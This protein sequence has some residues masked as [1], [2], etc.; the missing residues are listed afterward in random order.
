MATTPCYS[1][2]FIAELRYIFLLFYCL[3][4]RHHFLLTF[5]IF[6]WE[7]IEATAN[8]C[9]LTLTKNII[10]VKEK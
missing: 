3:L 9:S 6:F 8:I 7:K 2:P 10:I 5:F 1:A 4:I